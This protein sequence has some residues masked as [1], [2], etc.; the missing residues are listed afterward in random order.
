MSARS[1]DLPPLRRARTREG[2][3]LERATQVSSPMAKCSSSDQRSANCVRTQPSPDDIEATIQE[4]TR[5]ALRG[6]LDSPVTAAPAGRHYP[7]SKKRG[8][9]DQ[10]AMAR[11]GAIKRE[12]VGFIEFA[13]CSARRG[14]GSWLRL[15]PVPITTGRKVQERGVCRTM[16]TGSIRPLGLP[17]PGWPSTGNS[18]Y[19]R[20]KSPPRTTPR[21]HHQR[22]GQ[23]VGESPRLAT[24]SSSPPGLPRR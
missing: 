13:R 6:D 23:A 3:W 19:I 16:S 4:I 17:D 8:D 1:E 15:K 14:S 9:S 18:H 12:V 11:L 24:C 21:H 20:L 2:P 22:V 5:R 7:N 10:D